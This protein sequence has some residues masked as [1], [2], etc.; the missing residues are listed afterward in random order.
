MKSL[1]IALSCA[2]LL[3]AC[4]TASQPDAPKPPKVGMANP[5]AVYCEQ[6][7]GTLV[8]VQSPQGVRSDCKLPGGEVIDEWEL[9][10]RD[11]PQSAK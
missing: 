6:K 7:G 4:T 9:W 1:L 5:A 2:C 3:S 8:P 11:H 10:R